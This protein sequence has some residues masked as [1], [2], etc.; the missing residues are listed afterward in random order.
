MADAWIPGAK[1]ISAQTDGGVLRG[2]APRVVWQALSADPQRISA[3]SAAQ[4]LCQAGR[5]PHLVWNPLSG[6]IAQ[7]IPAV[8]AGCSLGAPEGLD[9]GAA[10]EWPPPAINNQGRLCVQIC[11]VAPVW[12]PFTEGPM[13]R[14]ELILDWLDTWHVPCRWPAGRPAPYMLARGAERSRAVW[15]IG[16]H[17]G[18]SQVPGWDTAGPGN[19]DI[20][21][22]GGP[23]ETCCARVPHQRPDGAVSRDGQHV[24]HGMDR[25][26]DE[27]LSRDSRDDLETML[28]PAMAAENGGVAALANA[29]Y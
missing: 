13:N 5:P 16:G 25:H 9:Y 17:Y 20:D 22:I 24:G 29:P 26:M 21:L 1:R 11:V 8:R 3:C 15:A 6:E 14:L 27:G 10:P 7:L 18:A 28:E 19:I 2:G 12:E 4:R 23:H